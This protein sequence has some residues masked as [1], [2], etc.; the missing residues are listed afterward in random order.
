MTIQD[1]YDLAKENG[2][3]D[4][5]IGINDECGDFAYAMGAYVFERDSQKVVTFLD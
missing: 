4:Y 3:L 1:L 2:W 5:Q